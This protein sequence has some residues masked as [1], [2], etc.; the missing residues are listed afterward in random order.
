MRL[1][2][3]RWQITSIHRDGADLVLAY[4][5]DKLAKK[6]ADRSG[7]RMKVIDEKHVYCRLRP[8]EDD[9]ESLY[10]LLRHL[11]RLPNESV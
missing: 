4:R 11:L 8:G 5:S 9:D 10:R 1:L 2:A 6:L 3:G 7:G